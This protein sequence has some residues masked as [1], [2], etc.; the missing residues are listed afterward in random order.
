MSTGLAQAEIWKTNVTWPHKTTSLRRYH[1]NLWMGV[2]PVCLKTYAA[3]WV[4]AS[5]GIVT[6]GCIQVEIWNTLFAMWLHKTTWSNDHLTL[7]VG[8]LHCVLL[9]Y[10]N[11]AS[12]NLVIMTLRDSSAPATHIFWTKICH[13]FP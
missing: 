10:N 8:T 12:W 4:E 9:R 13:N 11:K 6:I 3:F 5:C 2:P 7:C 1:A